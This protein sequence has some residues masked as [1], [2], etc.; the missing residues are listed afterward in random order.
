VPP[1]RE[2]VF[3]AANGVIGI[4]PAPEPEK[5]NR[6]LVNARV[7]HIT[8]IIGPALVHH[9]DSFAIARG[10]HL[11]LCGLGAFGVAENDDIADRVRSEYTIRLV[12]SAAQW[13][14]PWGR[15]GCGS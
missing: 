12:R 5:I 1:D 13:T 3:H 14:S 9:A 7:Q 15:S 11:D 8:L 2:V 6:H 4:G 10:W